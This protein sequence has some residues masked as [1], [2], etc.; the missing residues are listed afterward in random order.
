M[1]HRIPGRKLNRSVIHRRCLYK[2]QVTQLIEHE[3]IETTVA[4]AKELRRNTDKIITLAKRWENARDG[5]A[6]TKAH[7]YLCTASAG[8]KL[9]ALAKRFIDRQGGYTRVLKTRN[10]RGD[11]APMAMV[12][13]TETEHS[14]L[15][16]DQLDLK[17]QRK[18]KYRRQPKVGLAQLLD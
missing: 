17:E 18:T 9:D 10:R 5:R 4:K 2:T 11:C 13:L 14:I 1:R 6:K 15:T 3:R 7:A 8:K 12:E 16:R